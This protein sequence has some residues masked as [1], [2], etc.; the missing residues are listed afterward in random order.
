MSIIFMSLIHFLSDSVLLKTFIVTVFISS[1]RHC[2]VRLLLQTKS[3]FP[4]LREGGRISVLDHLF[5]II[6]H[7]I[8]SVPVVSLHNVLS[9]QTYL[10]LVLRKNSSLVHSVR[11]YS[12]LISLSRFD[13]IVGICWTIRVLSVLIV[14]VSEH[15]FMFGHA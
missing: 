10:F 12:S 14:I 13:S 4:H 8:S 15:F 2:S 6:L 3:S 1:A 9:S 11:T 7:S 5:S